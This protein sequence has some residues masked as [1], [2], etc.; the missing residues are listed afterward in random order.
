ML[1][2]GILFP[3]YDPMLLVSAVAQAAP[4]LGIVITSSTSLEQPFP[5]ARRFATLDAFTGGRIGWNIVTGST[6]QVTEGLFGITHYD[7]DTRYDVA[8]EFVD[9]CRTLWEDA[10]DDD[11]VVL[12]DQRHFRARSQ[13]ALGF[14]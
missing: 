6:A 7:H 5:T 9:V 4:S 8:D 13:N 14:G 10:W 1:S 11:A 3:G 2:H 12:D